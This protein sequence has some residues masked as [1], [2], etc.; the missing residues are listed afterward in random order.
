MGVKWKKTE[1]DL[2]MNFVISWNAFEDLLNIISNIVIL[3]VASEFLL[4][5]LLRFQKK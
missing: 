4:T 2:V 5:F 1:E 3:I